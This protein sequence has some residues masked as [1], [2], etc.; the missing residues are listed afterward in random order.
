MAAEKKRK[1]KLCLDTSPEN[2]LLGHRNHGRQKRKRARGEKNNKVCLTEG[3]TRRSASY[4]QGLSQA[5]AVG[6]DATR[7]RGLL[8]LLQRLTAAVPNE[9][10]TWDE[11]QRATQIKRLIGQSISE[12]ISDTLDAAREEER[13]DE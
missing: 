12:R 3:K 10:H 7:A 13:R 8:R 6:Q 2:F 4:L 5:H 1:G 9:L 11:K